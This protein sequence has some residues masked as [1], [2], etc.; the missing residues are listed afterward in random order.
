MFEMKLC[1]AADHPL[2][3]RN[4]ARCQRL[5]IVLNAHQETAIFNDRN[6][7]RFRDA[8]TPTAFVEML[9]E[10]RIVDGRFGGFEGSV[11]ILGAEAVEA[12]LDPESSVALS[13][14][15]GGQANLA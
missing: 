2:H 15:R 13:Q 11:K 8:G 12:V 9:E 7:D 3:R 4:I 14:G 1:A 5:G 6:L 10:S